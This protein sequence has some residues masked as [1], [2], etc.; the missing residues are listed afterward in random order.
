[1]KNIYHSS[2][3]TKE[4]RFDMHLYYVMSVQWYKWTCMYLIS[5]FQITWNRKCKHHTDVYLEESQEI[6]EFQ[7]DIEKARIGS[8]TIIQTLFHF[9]V[10]LLEAQVSTYNIYTGF[11]MEGQNKIIE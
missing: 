9:D 11:H 2:R 4:K 5:A 1:M 7:L 8:L 6:W 10:Q 3:L